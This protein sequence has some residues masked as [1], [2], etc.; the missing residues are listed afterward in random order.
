M[1]PGPFERWSYSDPLWLLTALAWLAVSVSIL[2]GQLEL[3]P[4]PV[5]IER[6]AWLLASHCLV[7]VVS[8]VAST[9]A[10]SLWSLQLRGRAVLGGVGPVLIFVALAAVLRE[11]SWPQPLIL[12]AAL[13]VLMSSTTSS[14]NTL[15]YCLLL[16]VASTH[17]VRSPSALSL[18]ALVA[19]AAVSVLGLI[20]SNAR[21]VLTRFM[22]RRDPASLGSQWSYR[23]SR[24]GLGTALLACGVVLA[25]A[26]TVSRGTAAYRS[27]LDERSNRDPATAAAPQSPEGE[28]LAQWM[29]SVS[30]GSSAGERSDEVLAQVALR[31]ARSGQ[32]VLDGRVLYF[33]VTTLDTFGADRMSR[34]LTSAPEPLLDHA[35]GADDGW[36]EFS[37]P[38]ARAPLHVATVTQFAASTA[39]GGLAPLVRLEP[40]LAVRIDELSRL[41]DGTLLA[42]LEGERLEYALAADPRVA[43]LGADHPGPARHRQRRFLELPA[44]TPHLERITQRARE[45][46]EAANSDAERAL[47]IVQHFREYTYADADAESNLNGLESLARVVE[48]RSGYCATI[49]A[50]CVI[51]LRSQGIPARAVAGLLGAE[52]DA[53][54]SVY[55]LRQRHGHAWVEAHFEGLGWVQLEPTP[56]NAQARPSARG[57]FD[58]LADWSE[59]ASG[60]FASFVRGDGDAPGVAQLATLLSEGPAALARSAG[61]GRPFGL[62][63]A[64]ALLAASIY[65]VGRLLRRG[66]SRVRVSRTSAGRALAFEERLIAA[67]RARGAQV[68]A[69]RT[70]HEIAR[71]AA[72]RIEEPLAPA[73]ERAIRTLEAARFGGAELDSAQRRELEELLGQLSSSESRA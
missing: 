7:L 33:P 35:D 2:L 15:G 36:I 63:V 67:L 56:P 51:M 71:S 70:L 48:R 31:D 24:L 20:E 60:E 11:E 72:A 32:P 8:C 3:A 45:V 29:H 62:G 41:D 61:E 23:R 6:F 14:P 65:L 28:S 22:W 30:L 13:G 19:A 68:R 37:R 52:F 5:S 46:T 47:A 49:A 18:F 54:W 10:R 42:P 66:L 17:W 39:R 44:A 16:A 27:A 53:E 57:E 34:S 73:L 9:A 26:W 58:P 40:L 1:K 69:S 38:P 43:R 50:A 21:A 59:R 4:R 25:T 55:V 12:S 64:A